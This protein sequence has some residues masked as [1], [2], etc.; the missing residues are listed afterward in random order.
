MTVSTGTVISAALPPDEKG[1]LQP[2]VPTV[3]K[4]QE[5]DSYVRNWHLLCLVPGYVIIIIIIII[6]YL[7]SN[8]HP[9]RSGFPKKM[10]IK[11]NQKQ[12][13]SGSVGSQ[14]LCKNRWLSWKNRRLHG[15]V[16][17]LVVFNF[18]EPWLHMGNWFLP[19]WEPWLWIWRTVLTTTRGLVQFMITVQH[20]KAQAI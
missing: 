20:N 3:R 19:S 2:T 12:R 18:W 9:K 11:G 8:L 13:T 15:G 1:P 17:Y 14:P 5:D 6:R 7:M 4:G 10:E 16:I